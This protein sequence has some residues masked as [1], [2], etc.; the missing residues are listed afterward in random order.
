M[1]AV[2]LVVGVMIYLRWLIV[3]LCYGLLV[4]V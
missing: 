3:F 1:V 4:K 2:S